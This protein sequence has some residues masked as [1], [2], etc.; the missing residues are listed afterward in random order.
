MYKKMLVVRIL[1]VSSERRKWTSIAIGLSDTL[2]QGP[3]GEPALAEMKN[4][5]RIS[6]VETME[7]KQVYEFS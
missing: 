1:F 2:D 5:I 3:A 4:W 6:E 7:Q